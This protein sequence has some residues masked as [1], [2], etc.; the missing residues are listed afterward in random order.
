MWKCTYG[1]WMI[2]FMLKMI[3][4]VE[5]AKTQISF[6]A[7]TETKLSTSLSSAFST[8]ASRPSS[9]LFRSM[10]HGHAK[11]R[12][13]L[14]GSCLCH[15][16]YFGVEL[17]KASRMHWGNK[18]LKAKLE[19]DPKKLKKIK[20]FL[21]DDIFKELDWLGEDFYPGT[22]GKMLHLLCRFVY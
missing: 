19:R 17:D 6:A 1:S 20:K 12:E 2:R 4:C 18:R 22:S 9:L 5:S 13:A 11:W 21:K 7:V 15:Y 10:V 14:G 8:G 3:L 16:R